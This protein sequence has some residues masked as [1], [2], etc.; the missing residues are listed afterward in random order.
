MMVVGDEGGGIEE[1]TARTGGAQYLTRPVQPEQWEALLM[2]VLA[3][4]LPETV[5]QP[6][7]DLAVESSHDA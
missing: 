6:D 4:A 5:P 3:P 1:M 7:T 2:H